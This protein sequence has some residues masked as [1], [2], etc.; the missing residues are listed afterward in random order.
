VSSEEG[1]YCT[2][3]EYFIF[4]NIKIAIKTPLQEVPRNTAKRKRQ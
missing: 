3:T 1:I 2:V 4:G